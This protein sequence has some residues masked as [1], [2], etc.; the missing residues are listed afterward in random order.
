MTDVEKKAARNLA[1]FK[2]VGENV[3]IM[4]VVTGGA[5][6]VQLM[7]LE[8]QGQFV[9]LRA[10]AAHADWFFT[11]DSGAAAVYGKAADA[12]SP[13][14]Y[15]LSADRGQ[16]LLTTDAPVRRLVPKADPQNGPASV[17]LVVEAAGAGSI[18]ISLA[19]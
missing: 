4:K 16:T 19:E 10:L 18:E 17:F 8:W 3:P 11:T 5:H 13:T 6:A 14:T 15:T 9:Y 7:P 12:A 2:K 1:P